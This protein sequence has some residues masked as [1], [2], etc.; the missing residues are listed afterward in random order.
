MVASD[1]VSVN[2]VAG[3]EGGWCMWHHHECHVEMKSKMDRSMRRAASD[4][5]IP[6]L[7]FSLH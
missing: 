6:T 2:A 5:S 7:V 4:S 3:V 1:E